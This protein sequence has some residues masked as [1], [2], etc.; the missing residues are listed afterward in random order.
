MLENYFFQKIQRLLMGLQFSLSFLDFFWETTLT[1]AFWNCQKTLQYKYLIHNK[2][3][4]KHH[5]FVYFAAVPFCWMTLNVSRWFYFHYIWM[6]SE[7]SNNTYHPFIILPVFQKY[8]FC[9]HLSFLVHFISSETALAYSVI[10]IFLCR[11]P[12][13]KVSSKLFI[14]HNV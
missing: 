4:K 3:R 5:S 1:V 8:I 14:I 13:F 6:N 12:C 10:V 9:Y 7:F 11:Q 2:F